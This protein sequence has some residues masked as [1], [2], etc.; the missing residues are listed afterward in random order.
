MSCKEF[1]I[2]DAR[3]CNCEGRQ[4]KD[5]DEW[6]KHKVIAHVHSIEAKWEK[7]RIL[8]ANSLVNICGLIGQKINL[9]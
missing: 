1:L 2:K 5:F 6:I 9:S 4:D 8:F 3:G 7:I